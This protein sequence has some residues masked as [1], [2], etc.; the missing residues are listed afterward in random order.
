M[1]APHA[2]RPG[3]CVGAPTSSP[4][5][6]AAAAPPPS[7]PLRRRRSSRHTRACNVRLA[8]SLPPL[9]AFAIARS[10][11]FSRVLSRPARL[12]VPSS[13]RPAHVLVL[14]ST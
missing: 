9:R 14:L 8:P 2:R 11:A 1:R 13:P 3:I 5:L 4:A 6:C 7:R 12:P 10:S